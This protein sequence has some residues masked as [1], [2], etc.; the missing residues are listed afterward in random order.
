MPIE[1]FGDGGMVVSGEKAIKLYQL[2]SLRAT[3][4]L[5]RDTGMRPNRHVNPRAI[6]K[7]LTGLKTNDFNKL[8][9]AVDRHIEAQQVKVV[10]VYEESKPDFN[11]EADT[12]E[13]FKD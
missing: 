2:V 11:D 4:K 12:G 5:Q 9:E 1:H 10:H 6:A 7:K 3:L 8:L 13:P